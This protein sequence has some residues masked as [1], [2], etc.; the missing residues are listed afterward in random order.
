MNMKNILKNISIFA[1]IF[2]FAIPA[3]I[4]GVYKGDYAHANFYIS[5]WCVYEIMKSN[6]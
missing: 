1:P 3:L 2:L 4:L 6:K 5:L